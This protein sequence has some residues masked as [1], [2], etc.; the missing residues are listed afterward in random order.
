[1]GYGLRPTAFEDTISSRKDDDGASS[2]VSICCAI[3][4]DI[5]NGTVLP[6]VSD[7]EIDVFT[8]CLNKA[9]ILVVG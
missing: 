7:A 1:M 9:L 5:S 8:A 3:R 6:F 2:C 4:V